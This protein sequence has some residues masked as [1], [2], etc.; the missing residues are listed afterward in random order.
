MA[1]NWIIPKRYLRLRLFSGRQELKETKLLS[2][3]D[4][5]TKISFEVTANIN[6]AANDARI[7]ITGLTREKM[8]YLA[9][10]FTNW[11]NFQ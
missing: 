5:N 4:V 7:T 2:D 8:A 11:T 6:G 1:S 9:G 10:T 3:L